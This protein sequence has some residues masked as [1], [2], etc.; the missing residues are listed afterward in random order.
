MRAATTICELVRPAPG[1]QPTP[2]QVAD[3]AE[4]MLP[5]FARP[6]YVSVIDAL[7]KTATGKVQRAL[8]RKR[9]AEGAWDATTASAAAPTGTR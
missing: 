5:R 2:Q 8:L 1:A 4:R 7:P 6:R 9:G 3:H